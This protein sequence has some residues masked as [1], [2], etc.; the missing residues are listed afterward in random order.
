MDLSFLPALNAAL[1]GLAAGLLIVGYVLIKRRRIAAHRACMIAAFG[2]STLFLILYL[3]HK[4]WKASTGGGLHTSFNRVGLSKALYL[5]VLLSHL[6][7]AMVVPVLAIWLIR[8]GLRRQD[9][10]HRRLARI[11]LPLWLYVSFTGILIYVLLYHLNPPSA[12]TGPA[13]GVP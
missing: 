8:L 5:A 11:A 13:G 4:G 9:A 12:G 3:T 7:L 6:V 1:N 10:R 2:V